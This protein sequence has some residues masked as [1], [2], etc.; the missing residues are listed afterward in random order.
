MVAPL[1]TALM[2]SIPTENAG[3]GSA[4]NNAISR[5]GPQLASAAI[6]V[7][8]T[9]TFYAGLAARVPGLDPNSPEL[10]AAVAPLDAPNPSL[11][12][13]VQDAAHEASTDSFH[14]AMLIA[15]GLLLAGAAVNA[16]GIKNSGTTATAPDVELQAVAG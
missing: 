14:L 4:I 13:A 3:L 6:F 16:V 5:V 2:S 12:P 8:I 1:T 15:A 10:R 11:P 9:A 7:V